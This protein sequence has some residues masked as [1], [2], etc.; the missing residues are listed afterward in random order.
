L[1]LKEKVLELLRRPDVVDKY[2]MEF[3]EV[4]DYFRCT[5]SEL[6]NIVKELKREQLVVAIPFKR[7]GRWYLK[8]YSPPHNEIPVRDRIE[9][10]FTE[11]AIPPWVKTRVFRGAKMIFVGEYGKRPGFTIIDYSE[12]SPLIFRSKLAGGS[13]N[14]IIN[15]RKRSKYK[16]KRDGRV[17]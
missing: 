14:E 4:K 16:C 1:P 3:Y 5:K 12:D 2:G 7:A 10:I 17:I 6:N 8:Y 9:E 13:K 11:L 15:Y